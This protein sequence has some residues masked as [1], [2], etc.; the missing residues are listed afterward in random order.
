[1]IV[2]VE[3]EIF[4]CCKTNPFE[5]HSGNQKVIIHGEKSSEKKRQL[6]TTRIFPSE[7]DACHLQ[8]LLLVLLQHRMIQR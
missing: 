8:P 5:W 3:M 1:M 6:Q 2:V 4:C 7:S